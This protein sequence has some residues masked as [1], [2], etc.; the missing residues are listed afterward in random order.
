MGYVKPSTKLTFYKTFFLAQWKF[1]IH[2]IL[3]CMSA[4]RTT[5]NE[6]S[7]SMAS[8]VICLATRRK[9]NFSKYIFDNLVR[10]VD[11]PSKF[12]MYPRFLQLIINAQI[13]DLSSH[14]TKYTSATLTQKVFAN[15]RRVGKGFSGVD[16][17]LFDG[18]LVLQQAQDVEDVAEDEDAVNETYA[19][20]TKKVRNLEQDKVA[21]A[22]EITKLKQRVRRLEKKRQFKSLVLKRLRKVRTAQ[23]VESS[24]YTI[25]DDQEDPSK[26]GGIAKIDADE[27]VTLE[28]VDAEIT[29]DAD[30]TDKAEPV[31][32]EEVIKVVTA[33]KLI[34]KVVTTVA[35]TI[36]VDLVPKASAARRRMG[37]IVQDP[38][39]ASI[40]LVIVQSE[41]KSKDKGK[42][43]LVEEPKPLKRQAQIEQ[44]EAF[45]IELEAELNANINWNDVV[46]QVKRKERQ[47]NTVKRYQA[48][49]RKHIT[50]AQA[51]KN[52]ME[53]EEEGSNRKN[54][55]SE[56]RAVKKK[57]IDEEVIKGH[58]RN[59]NRLEGCI[60]KETI[61]EE[62]IKVFSEYHKS[63]ETIGILPDKHETDEN[64]EG[65]PL[66]ASKSSEVSVEL[67]QKAHLY[68]ERELAISKKS[69][70]E[71]VRWISYGP[72]TTVVKYDDYN[73]NGYTFHTK[74]HDGKVYQNSG[75]AVEAIDLH[76]SKE[77][78]TTRQAFYYE[79]L[80]EI[81]KS[82]ENEETKFRVDDDGVMWFG[83]RLC[84]LSDPTLRE[85]VLSEAHS[86]PFSI[87][88]EF[89]YNNSW[90]ASIKAAPYELLYG[91]NCR[92]PICWNEVGER[93]IEGPKLIE[94]TNEK[95][96]VA[97]E[98]LKEA[99]SQQKSYADRYRTC[100]VF[101]PRDRVFL[102][103]SPCRGV[104]HFG[105][106]GKLSLRFIG[107]IK[108]LDRLGEVSYRLA[109]P[110]Q[111]SH[112]HNVFHVSLLIGFKY[113]PLHVVSYPLNQIRE[114]LSLAEEPEKILDR[115]ERVMRNKTISFVKI[116]WK[117]HPEREATWETEES[118]RASYPC[119]FS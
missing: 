42:G 11:R 38:K 10:I 100:L 9:F 31:E 67:F 8:A 84:V 94:V 58:V 35:T 49:K 63:M 80:Q 13:A 29:K 71:T 87:H 105:I 23:R 69:V 6:F 117:N 26:Q 52:I 25:M 107:P 78:T 102:K 85:A 64:E 118:M 39:E 55:S 76:I 4:K 106:K 77:V 92:A 72:H 66:S 70:S 119:V 104:R 50:K 22:I 20:L 57:R 90:H 14:N 18:M 116:L 47:D 113:H 88:L 89:A 59:R 79:V 83:D 108:I 97:K 65:K 17:P 21:Q 60:A 19:S 53:I 12:Y 81:W 109:L 61:V 103:V 111:L 62:I 3:Q 43:I 73:I 91:W 75:V 24:T 86:S 48:L 44:A 56:Q 51:R 95:V 114:D 34:T 46:D 32:V 68:V 110:P 40:A 93:V 115:Q 27:D 112:V 96:D 33:A 28:E 99:R 36:T 45:A 37:V 54:E 16:T 1:L 2:T 30:E 74:C 15:I 82:E 98:K 5:W 41:V 7:P 101:N